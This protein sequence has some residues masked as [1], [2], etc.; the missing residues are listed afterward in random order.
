MTDYIE[1]WE[2][3]GCGRIEAPQPCIGLCRDRKV[4]FVRKEEHEVILAERDA[5][6]DRLDRA[7]AML[8][9]FGHAKPR[10]GQYDKAWTALQGEIRQALA[11]LDTTE[12][13]GRIAAPADTTPVQIRQR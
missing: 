9:R 4:R 2:C 7:H 8:L 12:V 11:C 13:I 5:L 1:A 10:K 3:M 6:R